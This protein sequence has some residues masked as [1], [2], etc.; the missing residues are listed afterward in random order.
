MIKT[1]ERLIPKVPKT[2]FNCCILKHFV[3]I[4]YC[5]KSDVYF[6]F[7]YKAKYFSMTLSHDLI[8]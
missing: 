6:G 2:V 3:V 1:D 4:R 5:D 8:A 7:Y